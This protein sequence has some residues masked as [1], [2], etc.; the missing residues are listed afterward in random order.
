MCCT[1][2]ANVVRS[3]ASGE[4]YP[5]A[6]DHRDALEHLEN[7]NEPATAADISLVSDVVLPAI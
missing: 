2:C 5:G 7:T 3:P 6:V 4:L 1:S